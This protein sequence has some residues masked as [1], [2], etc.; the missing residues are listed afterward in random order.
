MPTFGAD[1]ARGSRLRDGAIAIAGGVLVTTLVL[2]ASG[3][4]TD[5]VSDFF[6]AASY[7]MAKGQNVVNTIIVDF[8]AIDTL[9]EMAVLGVAGFGVYALLKLRARGRGND[10]DT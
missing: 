10:G 5:A 2:A 4:D 9:G 7:P 3:I 8:R 1:T 6:M